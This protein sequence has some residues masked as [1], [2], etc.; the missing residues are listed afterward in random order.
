MNV[1]VILAGWRRRSPGGNAHFS[2]NDYVRLVSDSS[3]VHVHRSLASDP[4]NTVH[5]TVVTHGLRIERVRRDA[6]VVLAARETNLVLA[7]R[8]CADVFIG[9]IAWIKSDSSFELLNYM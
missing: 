8:I 4:E 5:I 9:Q 3:S 1:Y 6:A 7:N 2:S